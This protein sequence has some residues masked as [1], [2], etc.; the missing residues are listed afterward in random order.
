MGNL[1]KK[2]E[3]QANDH[4]SIKGSGGTLSTISQFGQHFTKFSKTVSY[5][6]NIAAQSSHLEVLLLSKFWSEMGK[7]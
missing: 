4:H 2:Q 5:E 7:F 1:N 6:V 3:N